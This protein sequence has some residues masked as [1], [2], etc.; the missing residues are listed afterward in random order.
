MAQRRVVL[1]VGL[2][3][4]GTSFLQRVL[5][6][7]VEALA[8]HGIHLG[9]PRRRH[10]F[11]AALHLTGRNYDWDP[12][13][14][15]PA[16][17][18]EQI[19]ARARSTDGTTVISNEWL[20]TAPEDLARR[21]VAELAG[22]EV[23]VVIT[24]RDLARQLPAEWQEGVKH[25][26]GVSWPEFLKTVLGDGSRA[27]LRERFWS[28]QD[29]L[30]VAHRWGGDLPPGQVHVVTCPP[31]GA[32]PSV[33]W[34]RFAHVLEVP[35]ESVAL[36]S[37]GINTS[38]G[39]AQV[40][41]LRRVNSVFPRRGQELRH[42]A[43]VKRYLVGEVLA[44]QAGERTV[45]PQRWR[46]RVEEVTADWETQIASRQYDVI[47][48][49]ADLRL[50]GQANGK[51]KRDNDL[52]LKAFA[53]STRDLLVEIET[54]R[55]ELAEARGRKSSGLVARVRNRLTRGEAPDEDDLP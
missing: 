36:P 50:T 28:A 49:L 46:R 30:S 55:A 16:Q 43:L 40:E 37:R 25:G 13:G 21:A 34:G 24:V 31:P 42:R 33:L 54:L 6:D 47:G 20:S 10:M 19:R 29:P 5:W 27:E 39:R 18:W 48:D 12:V 22:L 45:L 52:V 8:D 15:E 2:P 32:D 9:A 51:L 44:P 1:H 17:A 23:H 41:V 38:L 14:I 4:T 11:A 53:E 26:R 3:K 35:P 7:N